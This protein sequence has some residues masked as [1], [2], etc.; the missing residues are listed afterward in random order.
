MNCC[1]CDRFICNLCIGNHIIDDT[2][3]LINIRKYDSLCKIHSNAFCFYCEQ[4]KNNLYIYCKVNHKSHQLI[5]ISELKYIQS[6]KH[7]LE[8]DIFTLENKLNSLSE[9]KHK[10]VHFI[11]SLKKSRELELK[12]IKLLLSTYQYEENHYN[13]NFYVMQN[14][15]KC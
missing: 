3:N 14:L 6:Q 1:K 12:F 13:L 15:K 8:K 5:D 7:N 4:C 9:M 2:H 10:I 11:D